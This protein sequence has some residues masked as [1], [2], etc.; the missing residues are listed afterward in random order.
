MIPTILP[1]SPSGESFSALPW[2]QKFQEF[3]CG[4]GGAVI[5][6]QER[7]VK[8]WFCFHAPEGFILLDAEGYEF[9]MLPLDVRSQRNFQFHSED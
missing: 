7:I 8:V 2:K 3:G 9:D 1:L 5:Y 6:F 4:D